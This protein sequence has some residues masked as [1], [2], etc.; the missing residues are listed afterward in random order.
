MRKKQRILTSVVLGILIPAV[1]SL[2]ALQ[3]EDF[4]QGKVHFID[5]PGL[6]LEQRAE[7]AFKE[8]GSGQLFLLGY[9][10]DSRHGIR[11]GCDRDIAGNYTVRRKNNRIKISRRGSLSRSVSTTKENRPAG[12]LLLRDGRQILDTSLLDPEQQYIFED[13]PLYW[14][15]EASAEESFAYLEKIFNKSESNLQE[16]LIFPL[17]I[18]NTSKTTPFLRNVGLGDY[19]FEVKKDAVFWLGNVKDSIS[20]NALKEIFSKSSHTELKKQVV[21]AIQLSD[22][23]N[24]I[25]ELIR[26]AK[27]ESNREVKKSA[28]FWLGQKAGEECT[29]ALKEVVESGEDTELKKSAVFAI[30]QLPKD[31]AVPLLIDIA[32]TNKNPAVKKSA[33]FWLGQTGDEEALKFFEDILLK[34]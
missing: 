25:Q 16:E 3:S 4:L 2:L 22:Q 13:I 29:A 8:A 28:I 12:L 11:F 10:F 34:K 15:G 32:K 7:A 26:I 27:K 31:Q 24:A 19:D 30:S 20:L 23:E 9:L 33:I 18:H 5:K 6:S 1:S 17:S 21:F 14:V